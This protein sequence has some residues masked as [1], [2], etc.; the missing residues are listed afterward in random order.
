M[1]DSHHID[2]SEGRLCKSATH[3]CNNHRNDNNH[4]SNNNINNNNHRNNNCNNNN[5]NN[6]HINCNNYISSDNNDVDSDKDYV[7]NIDKII[8]GFFKLN[9]NR[10]YTRQITQERK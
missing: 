5:D 4:N 9:L 8:I 10:I 1:L 3:E 7:H 2:F 6:I